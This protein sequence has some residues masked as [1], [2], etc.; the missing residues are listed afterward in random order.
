[1][2]FAT[3]VP[4]HFEVKGTTETINT[5]DKTNAM[6]L[7]NININVSETHPDFPAMYMAN[8]LL[9]GGAFL[10]SRI[11]QRLRENE[12]MSYGAG[13]F[14]NSNYRYDVSSW[15]IYAM[16]NP[17]YK[18][19]LDSALH[20]EVDKALKGGFTKDELDKSKNAWL[21]GNKTS[22]GMNDFLAR[23]LRWY[24][25]DDRDLIDFTDFENK[26]RSVSLEAVNAA[27]R[28]YF[29]KSKLVMVYSGDFE[30]GKTDKPAEKKGF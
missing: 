2:K 8:E 5:P 18:G 30:K 26:I 21:E 19:R 28:K 24:M 20:Q 6:L 9:G 15:G 25:R 14:M 7:A 12:G 10:S 11:P 3:I 13:T 4:K 16:F 29:D 27:L 22:L 23:Q 1:M 17:L